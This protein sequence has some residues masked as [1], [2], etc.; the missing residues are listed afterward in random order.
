MAP[1]GAARHGLIGTF[2]C[3]SAQGTVKLVSSTLPSAY[4]DR[5]STDQ[6]CRLYGFSFQ[7]RGP[8]ACLGSLNRVPPHNMG[9]WPTFPLSSLVPVKRAHEPTMHFRLTRRLLIIY[10][11]FNLIMFNSVTFLICSYRHSLRC[12]SKYKMDTKNTVIII[13]LTVDIIKMFFFL[14]TGLIKPRFPVLL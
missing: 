6:H 1:R 7:T 14:K 5:N 8:R 11:I 10:F 9:N 13:I 4:M 3:P 12:K 2:S